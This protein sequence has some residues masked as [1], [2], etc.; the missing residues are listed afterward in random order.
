MQKINRRCGFF[1][2]FSVLS[3]N[4][5]RAEQRMQATNE[6]EYY[7]SSTTTSQ[8]F[9]EYQRYRFKGKNPIKFQ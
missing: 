4:V 7:T 1:T 6:I 5:T 3:K 9:G 2:L 8:T